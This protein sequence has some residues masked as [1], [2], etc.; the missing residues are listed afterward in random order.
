MLTVIIETKKKINNSV[1]TVAFE[2]DARNELL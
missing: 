1:G 2:L